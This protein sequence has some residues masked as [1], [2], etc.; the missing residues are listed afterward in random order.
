MILVMKKELK[1]GVIEN[2]KMAFICRF[3]FDLNDF[4]TIDKLFNR[5]EVMLEPNQKN[6]SM[7][8]KIQSLLSLFIF[9]LFIVSCNDLYCI[10]F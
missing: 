4:S 2:F 3:T 9:T 10:L 6:I 8:I 5:N 7:S 1:S